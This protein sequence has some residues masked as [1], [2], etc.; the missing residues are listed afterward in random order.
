M[1][2]WTYS[3][4]EGYETCPRQFHAKYVLKRFPFVATEATK[5]GDAVHKAFENRIEHGDALPNNMSQWTKLVDQ[6]ARLPGTKLIEKKLAVD[7]SFET[8]DYWSAWSRGKVDLTVINKDAA[9]MVDWKTGKFK[10]SEQLMLYA[11]YGFANWPQVQKIETGFVW[12]KDR[13]LTKKV[14]TREEQPIIWQEFAPRVRRL[15]LAHEKDQW[16]ARPSGLCKGWCPV[17]D[18]EHYKAQ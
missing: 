3:H 15:E 14:W 7:R 18:C 10:P 8:C 9:V 16:P 1:S 6:F 13:K 11:G 2:A 4:L 5:W 12:L 17:T